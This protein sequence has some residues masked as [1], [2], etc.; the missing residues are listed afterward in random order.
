MIRHLA[1][2]LMALGSLG[3]SGMPATAGS[4]TPRATATEPIVP[5]V[6]PTT[7]PGLDRRLADDYRNALTRQGFQIVS[8]I[9]TDTR[10]ARGLRRAEIT[11]RTRGASLT[12]VRPE[13][14]RLLGPGANPRLALDQIAIRPLRSDGRPLGIITVSVADLDRWLKAQ[15]PDTEFYR[16]WTLTGPGR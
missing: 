15:M 12:A 2:V 6:L 13:V 7:P 16:R 11:Y 9:I 8:L 1:V 5:T 4:P 3:A 14:V 10:A